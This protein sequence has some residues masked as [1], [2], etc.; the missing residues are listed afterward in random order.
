MNKK[1]ILIAANKYWG[2]SNYYVSSATQGEKMIPFAYS[3]AR[4]FDNVT[5][6]RQVIKRMQPKYLGL[7]KWKVIE[8]KD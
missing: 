2:G 6:I 1:Y 7:T 5:E 8:V 4:R 3:I